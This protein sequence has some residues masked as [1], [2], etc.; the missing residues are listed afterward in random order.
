M[1]QLM[2]WC[3]DCGVVRST[4]GM[5]WR[6]QEIKSETFIPAGIAFSKSVTLASDSTDLKLS[7]C[8]AH[9]SEA[10]LSWPYSKRKII[11]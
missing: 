1:A 7:Q 9:M 6:N 3:I 5:K 2:T 8:L 11:Q 10:W 4:E